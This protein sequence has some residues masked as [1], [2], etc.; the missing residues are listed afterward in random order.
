VGY[1][2]TNGYLKGGV[3]AWKTAGGQTDKIEEIAAEEFAAE[4]NKRQDGINLLDVRRKSEYDTE[5]LLGAENF[6]LDFINQ[7]MSMIDRNKKY[8]VH[9]AGGYRSVIAISILKARGF[10][11]LVN[12]QGGYKALSATGLKR[13]AYERQITEL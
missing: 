10:H 6:P 12:I 2:N 7:H 8:Y 5:H 13:S 3:Q 4:F 11:N 1:D 9:C